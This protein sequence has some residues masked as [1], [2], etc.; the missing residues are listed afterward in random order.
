MTQLA[1]YHFLDNMILFFFIIMMIAIIMGTLAY[2]TT[3]RQI[4]DEIHEF[5]ILSQLQIQAVQHTHVIK[6]VSEI[7]KKTISEGKQADH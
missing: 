1:M 4:K 2:I 5:V 7:S 6:E 3:Q